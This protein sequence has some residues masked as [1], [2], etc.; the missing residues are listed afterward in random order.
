MRVIIALSLLLLLASGCARYGHKRVSTDGTVVKT[1]V[2][3]FLMW[4]KATSVA[5]KT[6]DGPYA[7]EMEVGEIAAGTEVEKLEPLIKA[8]VEAAVK[9]T[10]TAMG[11]P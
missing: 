5:G 7:H 1:S 3:A 10:L 11:V 6:V 2:Q 9:G 4:G 8:T